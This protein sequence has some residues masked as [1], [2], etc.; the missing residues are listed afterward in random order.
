MKSSEMTIADLKRIVEQQFG[1]LI[2]SDIDLLKKEAPNLVLG[3]KVGYGPRFVTTAAKLDADVES[4][5]QFYMNHKIH[6]YVRDVFIP[7]PNL[8]LLKKVFGW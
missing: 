8:D 1:S 2:E 5:I 7:A 6:Q 3:V 4:N